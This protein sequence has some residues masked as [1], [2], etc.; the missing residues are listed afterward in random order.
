M[1]RDPMRVPAAKRRQRLCYAP[2]PAFMSALPIT[3]H[4]VCNALG[5]RSE[6]VI[7]SLSS[8]RS[9]LTP[10]RH[11]T[12]EG[13]AGVLGWD[14]EPLG[15][16]LKDHDTRQARLAAHGAAL[17]A[18]PVGKACR[19]WGAHRVAVIVGTSTGG[20]ASTEQAYA[21]ARAHGQL[22]PDWDLQRKHAMQ[23]TVDVLQFVT[24][25]RGPGFAVSTACSSSA[26]ALGSAQRLVRAGIVD[27]V[28]VAGV[29]TLCETTLR[30]FASLEVLS[31]EACRPFSS[32]RRGINIGEGA[33]LLLLE[34]AGDAGV[35]LLS[36]GESSDAHHVSAPHPEGLGAVLAMQRALEQAG[37]EPER[38][39][40]VNA[41]AT[42]TPLNDVAEA[43]AIR[44]VFGGRVPVVATKG[45]TGHLLGAA[46]ATE[47][48]FAAVSVAQGWLPASLGSDPIDPE[49]G[50]DIVSERVELESDHVISNSLAFGGSNVAV[51]LGVVDP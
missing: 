32:D 46:G 17:L 10:H 14:P 18:E 6:D 2:R 30:G 38:I 26:K 11:G 3:A 39:G 15:G 8:G 49:L 27:A 42:G 13:L 44:D 31:P 22:P 7:E 41:H 25:A 24:G 36:V 37:L 51:L 16:S 40:H 47:A 9:G 34:R 20:I 28:V 33:A 23:A 1:L 29:D 12:G 35:A 19:R 21:H 50:I 48:V 4:A 43:R 5:A 45:Y